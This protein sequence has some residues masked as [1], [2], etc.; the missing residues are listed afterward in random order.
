MEN[1]TKDNLKIHRLSVKIFQQV[2]NCSGIKGEMNQGTQTLSFIVDINNE[3]KIFE[4][5]VQQ[6]TKFT[7]VCSFYILWA[8]VQ[9]VMNHVF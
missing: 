6:V 5:S 9:F 8:R 2:I 7:K 4:A 3:A 1:H